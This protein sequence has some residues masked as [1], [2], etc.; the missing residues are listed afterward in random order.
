MAQWRS[1][2]FVGTG[3]RVA[4]RIAELAHRLDVQEI[5]VV[6]WAYDEAVRRHS[7]RLLAE[8]A[9]LVPG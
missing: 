6:T 8:A 5:A 4:E 7:Y 1:S 3:T 9:C 2:A